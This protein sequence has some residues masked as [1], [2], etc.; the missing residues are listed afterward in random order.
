MLKSQHQYSS[1][2]YLV[3]LLGIYCRK[4][5]ATNC[6][7]TI[8]SSPCVREAFAR[9]YDRQISLLSTISF[10][11][12]PLLNRQKWSKFWKSCIDIAEQNVDLSHWLREKGGD[13]PKVS[14]M[15]DISWTPS[16]I[17]LGNTRTPCHRAVLSKSKKNPINLDINAI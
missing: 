8:R 5:V 10:L 13:T 14:Y 16:S 4:R 15:Y 3:G 9:H 12:W 2:P 7:S 1:I 6:S 17:T 11:V